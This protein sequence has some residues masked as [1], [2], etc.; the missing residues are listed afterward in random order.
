M[1][2]R[3][4]ALWR[5]EK[6]DHHSPCREDTETPAMYANESRNA[7]CHARYYEVRARRHE[8][9][10]C[11]CVCVCGWDAGCWCNSSKE[12]YGYKEPCNRECY[13]H[14]KKEHYLLQHTATYCNTLQHPKDAPIHT[15]TTTT[16]WGHS[17]TNHSCVCLCECMCVWETQKRPICTRKR[18]LQQTSIYSQKRIYTNTSIPWG[19]GAAPWMT[20]V[21]L[22]CGLPVYALALFAHPSEKLSFTSSVCRG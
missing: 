6:S 18:A 15:R 8:R 2:R 12:T 4:R 10:S 5:K 16:R 19:K 22:G 20:G 1:L 21:W 17:A 11:V 9:Q 7:S 3:L 13:R 14:S